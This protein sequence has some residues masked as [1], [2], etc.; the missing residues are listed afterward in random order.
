[1]DDVQLERLKSKLNLRNIVID[2]VI[3][4]AI[5][6]GFGWWLNTQLEAIKSEIR[7][8]ESA[9]NLKITAM[10][11]IQA[12]TAKL[13]SGFTY[14]TH[15]HKNVDYNK[16]QEDHDKLIRKLIE[17]ING[18]SLYVSTKL[19]NELQV[20]VNL[21]AGLR[22]VGEEQCL[23]YKQMVYDL[24]N[25]INSILRYETGV[26]IDRNTEMDKYTKLITDVNIKSEERIKN[27][28]EIYRK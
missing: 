19:A 15:H 6:L 16:W 12:E 17:V 18:N 4:G 10:T 20:I 26:E 3:I 22:K 27:M 14:Y 23:E 25:V 2:K 11:A 28:F 1:M 13:Y 24:N 9:L 5:I 21:H 8:N 7:M